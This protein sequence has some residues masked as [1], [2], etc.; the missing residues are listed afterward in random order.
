M[1]DTWGY[2]VTLLPI[3][4]G[5]NLVLKFKRDLRKK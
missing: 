2:Y 4:S 5:S 1:R 3:L